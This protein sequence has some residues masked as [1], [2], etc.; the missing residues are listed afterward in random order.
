MGII[1]R[2]KNDWKEARRYIE[3]AKITFQNDFTVNNY[4]ILKEEI[5]EEEITDSAQSRNGIN[6]EENSTN[7][8]NESTLDVKEKKADTTYYYKARKFIENN[9]YNARTLLTDGLNSNVTITFSCKLDP[10]PT[11]KKIEKIQT[12]QEM[13]FARDSVVK[14]LTEVIST[15]KHWE[16]V[17]IGLGKDNMIFKISFSPHRLSELNLEKINLRNMS[18]GK[19]IMY[20]VDLRNAHLEKSFF[21]KSEITYTKLSNVL[22]SGANLQEVDFEHSDLENADLKG[23]NLQGATF[24]NT[25]LKNANLQGAIIA[26][27]TFDNTNLEG[28]SFS[29]TTPFRI[30]FKN[31]KLRKA[32]LKGVNLSL[33]VLRGLDLRDVNFNWSTLFGVDFR[34]S[35]LPNIKLLSGAAFDKH[36]KIEGSYV[37]SAYWIKKLV[38]Q[39]NHN[40]L[41]Q[42]YQ[43]HK[44]SSEEIKEAAKTNK[45]LRNWDL[46]KPLYQVRL[47]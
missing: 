2:E 38:K 20:K 28:V 39:T 40:F 22:F 14:R 46:N 24:K 42:K 3:K 8:K 1:F 13:F 37:K 33:S 35:L 36:T 31:T 21:S 7:A 32:N 43:L 17:K 5:F 11:I 18:L 45:F 23:A 25:S 47:K 6:I 26:N 41:I 12:K 10:V 15:Y 30:T 9:F 29:K 16:K 27:A 44:L 34:G 4:E 19:T